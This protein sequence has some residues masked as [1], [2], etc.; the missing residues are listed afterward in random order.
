MRIIYKVF[1]SMLDAVY[2]NDSM[3]LYQ[4][5]FMRVC[6]CVC[7]CV[8]VYVFQILSLHT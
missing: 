1:R 2:L 5:Y 6:V 4:I 7:V 3:N 8:C